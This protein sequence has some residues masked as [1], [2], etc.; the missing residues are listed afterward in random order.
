MGPAACDVGEWSDAGSRDAGNCRPELI[1]P[2]P[3]A[4]FS[5][6]EKHLPGASRAYRAGN[7]EPFDF[8]NGLSVKPL[9][10]NGPIVSVANGRTEGSLPPGLSK[11]LF[12][13]SFLT[14]GPG[15]FGIVSLELALSSLLIPEIK[16]I[17]LN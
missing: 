5:L 3:G 7:Y 2:I 12:G 15:H 9:S 10:P 6:A 8:F 1:A 11:A 16:R 13:E 4:T 14:H 17:F